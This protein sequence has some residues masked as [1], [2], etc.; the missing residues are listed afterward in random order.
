M[1]PADLFLLLLS[2]CAGGFLAGLLGIGGGIIYVVIFSV[3]LERIGI[4]SRLM[5][6]AIIAN[7]MLAILFSSISGTIKHIRNKNF[8]PAEILGMGIPAALFSIL[9]TRLIQAGTWYTKERFTILFIAILVYTA[10]RLF[11]QKEVAVP[12]KP[13]KRSLLLNIVI[14]CLGGLLAALSG[15][16]GGIIMIPLT[17]TLL[18]YNIKKAT[19]IS[20]G[21]IVVITLAH[22]AYSMITEAGT[23]LQVPYSVGL[24]C[25]PVVLPVSLGS[26]VFSPLGVMAAFRA[27][28]KTLRISFAIV[29][30]CVIAKMVYSLIQ[31]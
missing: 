4:P 22:S 28:A 12:L 2:G 23:G 11:R 26:I 9:G 16:G 20:L 24:I 21:V 19:T 15:L 29:I 5:V 14:G 25:L 10:L 31:P 30:L 3:Y 6:S 7:S 8:F 1:E 18:H 17:T 13:E 27:S